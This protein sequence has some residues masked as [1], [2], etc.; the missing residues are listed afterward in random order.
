MKLS[1]DQRRDDGGQHLA[2]RGKGL[3]HKHCH[4]G[5]QHLGQVRQVL[6]GLRRETG[7]WHPAPVRCP[8]LPDDSRVS[9]IRGRYPRIP[10]LRLRLYGSVQAAQTLRGKPFVSVARFA[11]ADLAI[12]R[13]PAGIRHEHTRGFPGTLQEC[14]PAAA[15]W[16]WPCRSYAV[17]SGP[18][19]RVSL[20][21]VGGV[22][23]HMG[24]AAGD[25]RD[26]LLDRHRYVA[27][28]GRAA[29]TRSG[30]RKVIGRWRACSASG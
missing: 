19:H 21:C 7:N 15:M 22:L 12:A 27:E 26:M 29:R 11:G 6:R 5:D 9:R 4:E 3:L 13:H 20:R 23:A 25:R 17:P 8:A 16:R 24:E 1:N 14:F 2:D 30:S 28:H 10:E 18:Q